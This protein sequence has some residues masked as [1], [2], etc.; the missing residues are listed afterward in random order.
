[1]HRGASQGGF[2]EE[3]ACELMGSGVGNRGHV[4]QKVQPK[5]SPHEGQ[6]VLPWCPWPALAG[7]A[8]RKLDGILRA[9]PPSA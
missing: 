4:Q 9:P 6:E 7:A 2:L 8:A 3:E 1:M 5:S